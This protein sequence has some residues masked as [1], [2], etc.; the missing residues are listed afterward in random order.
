MN[1]ALAIIHMAEL[2]GLSQA[3][4]VIRDEDI[5]KKEQ[6]KSLEPPF[7]FPFRWAKKYLC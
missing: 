7:F 2:D 3:S 6:E 1:Y 5:K 4:Q